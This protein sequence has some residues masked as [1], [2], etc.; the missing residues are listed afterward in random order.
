M[1]V[2]DM[3]L[4]FT[5]NDWEVFCLYSL[6]GEAVSDPMATATTNPNMRHLSCKDFGEGLE[7]PKDFESFNVINLEG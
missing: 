5:F 3:S 6:S 7:Q 2:D 1:I 4:W